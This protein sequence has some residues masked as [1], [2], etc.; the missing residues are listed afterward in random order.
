MIGS[1]GDPGDRHGAT[2]AI[3]AFDGRTR[4]P[5]ADQREVVLTFRVEPG[6]CVRKV[7]PGLADVQSLQG[8]HLY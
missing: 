2:V 8:N 1:D 6:R 4:K 7:T 3:Q 5:A